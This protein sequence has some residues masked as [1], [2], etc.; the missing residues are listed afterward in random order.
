MTRDSETARQE[1][2]AAAKRRRQELGQ[3]PWPSDHPD[4]PSAEIIDLPRKWIVCIPGEPV[5]RFD[6]DTGR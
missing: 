1:Q 6:R 4:K 3:D 5:R 2:I